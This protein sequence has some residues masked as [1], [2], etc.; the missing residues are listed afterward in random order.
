MTAAV[1]LS[2]RA[3]E[4]RQVL[5]RRRLRRMLRPM[6]AL[7]PVLVV[8]AVLREQ[9]DV[10]REVAVIAPFMMMGALLG[11]A[12]L[13]G[14]SARAR[15]RAQKD[16]DAYLVE[17]RA[18]APALTPAERDRELE[19]L[20]ETGHHPAVVEEFRSLFESLPGGARPL[21]ALCVKDPDDWF[22]ASGPLKVRAVFA[23]PAGALL[24]AWGVVGISR[25]GFESIE[26]LGLVASCLPAIFTWKDDEL[27]DAQPGERLAWALA[28]TFMFFLLLVVGLLAIEA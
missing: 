9:P 3:R 8:A 28:G 21:P 11:A 16:R 20:A 14:S 2:P 7:F 10:P 27:A 24:L 23:Y 15:A 19:T 5:L 1:P 25:A 4:A 17:L 12:T 18:A 13:Y 22:R 26:W 6:V